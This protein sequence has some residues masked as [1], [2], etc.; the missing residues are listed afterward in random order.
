MTRKQVVAII[1]AR[2]NSKRL[3]NKNIGPLLGR[4]LIAYT[5]A[6]AQNSK[7]VD[8][9]IVSTESPQVEAVARKLGAEVHQRPANETTTRHWGS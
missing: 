4:P 8:R 9:I 7:L 1:P 5:I 2:G 6:S 3:P